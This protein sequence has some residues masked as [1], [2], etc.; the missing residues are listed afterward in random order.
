MREGRLEAHQE[1][2]PQAR[3]RPRRRRAAPAL[4]DGAERRMTDYRER[5]QGDHDVP[6]ARRV[7]PRRARLADRLDRRLRG[8][9]LRLHARGAR[10]RRGERRQDRGDQAAPTARRTTS[11]GASSSSSSSRSSSR[12]SPSAAS[13]PAS[14]S[15]SARRRSAAEQQKWATDDLLFISNY[16]EG[17]ERRISFAHFS[18]DPAKNDL[19]TLKVLAWDE[20][21]TPLHLDD[22]AKLLVEQLSWPADG[23]RVGRRDLA[24]ALAFRLRAPPPRGHH[25]LEGARDRA[26]RARARDP[27]P[28]QQRARDRDRRRPGHQA[29]EGVPGGA[30]PRSRRRRLRGHVRADDRLRVAL[31]PDRE[32]ERRRPTTREHLRSPT[33]SSRSSWR[34][35]STSADGDGQASATA[36][37]STSSA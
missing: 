12:S 19:P 15:R 7:P 31:G 33:R 21:D 20:L 24:R 28:N 4:L 22:V 3:R 25:D 32:S 35:S 10:D 17:D 34:R 6:V 26:R 11:R 29:D 23:G 9:D 13:S 30:R 16:G 14:S 2:V 27:R 8:A 37:T 5:A 18:Q 1:H 36:S